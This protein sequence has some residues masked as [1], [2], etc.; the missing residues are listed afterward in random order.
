MT[1]KKTEACGRC[2]MTTVVDAAVDGEE[3]DPFGD[4]RIE[5]DSETFSRISPAVW[6]SR[7]GARLNAAVQRFTYGR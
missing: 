7:V 2:S 3:R 1:E 4:E 5:V 6:L